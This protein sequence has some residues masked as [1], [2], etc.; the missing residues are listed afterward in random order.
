MQPSR[1]VPCANARW[2]CPCDS[3]DGRP[4][5]A[6]CL[7]CRE[8]QFCRAKTHFAPM[9]A[10]SA[11]PQPVFAPPQQQSRS[12]SVRCA[13][14]GCPCDSFDG[15]PGTHCCALC[16]EAPVCDQRTHVYNPPQF[17]S[18]PPPPTQMPAGQGAYYPHAPPAPPGPPPPS[19]FSAPMYA[20]QAPVAPPLAPPQQ[21]HQHQHQQQH[22][23]MPAASTASRCCRPGC[24][25][26]SWNGQPREHCSKNCRH[27]VPCAQ[28]VHTY[29]GPPPMATGYPPVQARTSAVA[30]CCNANC[31]CDSWN[32]MP[33]EYCSKSC[34]GNGNGCHIRSHVYVGPPPQTVHTRQGPGRVLQHVVSSIPFLGHRNM[35]CGN[36]KCRHANT[37]PSAKYCTKCGTPL[38]P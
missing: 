32:G 26:D 21:Q 19:Q 36:P 9:S 1:S 31:P 35:M 6:C 15:R 4:E 20:Q 28:R 17:F 18:P 7:A 16:Q 3:F 11:Y 37:Q 8:G 13:R 10:G 30:Q 12:V 14:R 24:P 29:T 5:T 33:G 38:P 23:A 34:K 25:C 2:G 27:G 22:F